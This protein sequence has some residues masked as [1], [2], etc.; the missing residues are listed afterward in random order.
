M[1]S[2]PPI[3]IITIPTNYF[4]L[5]ILS[6][7]TKSKKIITK[8]FKMVSTENSRA[9]RGSFGESL[10]PLSNLP[11]WFTRFYAKADLDIKSLCVLVAMDMDD[12]ECW[13]RIVASE[14]ENAPRIS[15]PEL[16][17]K[18]RITKNNPFILK[19]KLED[20]PVEGFVA[21]DGFVWSGSG[22]GKSARGKGDYLVLMDQVQFAYWFGPESWF[23]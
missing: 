7:E 17:S 8:A 12:Y 5:T 22:K 13:S 10:R 9:H 15:N 16:L 4:A 20:A 6:H 23:D 21:R 11:P 18:E 2:N 19:Y 3:S 14:N 1:K